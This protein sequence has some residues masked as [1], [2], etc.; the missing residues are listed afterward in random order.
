MKKASQPTAKKESPF[1]IIV[2]V[3][4][5]NPESVLRKLLL[6]PIYDKFELIIVDDRNP[7]DFKDFIGNLL[8]EA[9]FEWKI[10]TTEKIPE[11]W[12][13]KKFAVDRAVKEAKYNKIVTFD[14]DT[15]FSID[16]LEYV[17]ELDCENTA[18]YTGLIVGENNSNSF[19]SSMMKLDFNGFNILSVS[20][21]SA[22]IALYSN[23]NNQ[24]FS[25]KAYLAETP[26]LNNAQIQSG[27]D[28]FIFTN[29][30][31][32]YPTRGIIDEKF[33]TSTAVPSNFKSF[34]LQR[35]RWVSKSH[36]IPS[37]KS[38]TFS[39]VM[40][41]LYLW[42]LISVFVS[43]DDFFSLFL[44]KTIC[45][46]LLLSPALS[47]IKKPRQILYIIPTQ[48]FQIIYIVFATPV[49]IV[50]KDNKWR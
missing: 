25:K 11:N 3:H 10:I 1:S 14:D 6:S 18:Y 26:L 9:A 5:G 43:F 21:A 8:K 40:Y 27:D 15:N 39:V 48:I 23:A 46:T 31:K 28:T 13:P 2:P 41:M 37:K 24:V 12:T 45:D 29:L 16:Y 32:K 50:F 30:A 49:G 44:I 4:N 36:L 47:V 17:Y 19:I 38:L 7:K 34:F 35:M 42:L 20:T 33:V 22:G